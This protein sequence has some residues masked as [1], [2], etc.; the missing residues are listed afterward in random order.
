MGVD[1]LVLRVAVLQVADSR[2]GSG[3]SCGGPLQLEQYPIS[4]DRK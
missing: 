4:M 2:F 3:P 1:I